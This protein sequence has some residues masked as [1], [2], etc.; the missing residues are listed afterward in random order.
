MRTGSL[1]RP[2]EIASS[3]MAEVGVQATGLDNSAG[4]VGERLVPFVGETEVDRVACCR[5]EGNA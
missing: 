4:E 1:R 3:A 5:P 2:E